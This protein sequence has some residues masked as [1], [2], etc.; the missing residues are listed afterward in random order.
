[1]RELLRTTTTTEVREKA[2]WRLIDQETLARVA[3][4]DPFQEV[5]IAAMEG[6]RDQETLARIASVDPHPEV[7]FDTVQNLTIPADL[8]AIAE[9]ESEPEI[10]ELAR[11][12]AA[13]L[14]TPRAYH[15][16]FAVCDSCNTLL[17]APEGYW[18]EPLGTSNPWLLCSGCFPRWEPQGHSPSVARD[19]ARVWWKTGSD[20]KAR[21]A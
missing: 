19:R 12:M 8:A 15:R 13:A 14:E 10:R 11:K 2:V 16:I 9:S 17:V 20:R 3:R 7:R 5:R 4:N 18:A 21:R 1:M 6:L